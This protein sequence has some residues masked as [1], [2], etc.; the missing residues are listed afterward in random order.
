[1]KTFLLGML[2][3]LLFFLGGCATAAGPSRSEPT[4]YSPW[5]NPLGVT[6]PALKDWYTMPYY[7]P[8]LQ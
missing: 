3:A 5:E 4:A 8:Y 1:M 7:N 2:L 6:D